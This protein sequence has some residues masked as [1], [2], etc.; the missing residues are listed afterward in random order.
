M[1]YSR[2]AKA[3]FPE[4]QLDNGYAPLTPFCGK[5]APKEA[6]MECRG[7][8]A[9]E[10]GKRVGVYIRVSTEEQ[11]Q[12]ESPE[13]HEKRARMYAEV[14]GWVVVTV[15]NLA[16]FSG[17]TVMGHPECER[18]MADVKEGR[19]DG[20]IFSKLARLAR[21]T[22]ELLD[23][24]DF[25]RE[26][27]ADLISLQESI[28]TST[29]GG[30]FFY[31]I[32]ASLA[33]WEREEIADRVSASVQVRAKLGKSLGGAAPFGYLW[34]DGKLV[35][36]P[37][38]AP[39]RKLMYEL[40]LEERRVK[41][42]A[43]ILNERGYRT[44]RGAKFTGTTV[45]RLLMDPTAKGQHR[46]NYTTSKGTGK[47]WERKAEDEWTY[48]DVEPVVSEEVWNQVNAI[49]DERATKWAKRPAKKPCH[50]FTGLVHCHCGG[51][52]YVPS[53]SPK[54]ICQSCRHKIPV[55]DLERVFAEEL[56]NF[57]FS[58]DEIGAHLARADEEI[59]ES[60]ALLS[61]LE[62][63]RDRVRVEMDKLYRLYQDDGITVEGFR[64]RYRPMEERQAELGDELPRLQARIDFMRIRALSGSEIVGEAQ[65]LSSRWGELPE[66][67]KRGIV[68][69]IVERIEVG[70]GEIAIDLLYLPPPPKAPGGPHS[71]SSPST[72]ADRGRNYRGSSPRAARSGP[73]TRAGRAPAPRRPSP[74]R[75]AGAGPRGRRDETR[76]ARRGTARHCGPGSPRPA[77][78]PN[79]RRADPARWFQ[80][81]GCETAARAPVRRAGARRRASG[82]WSPR[83]PRRG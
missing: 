25:F 45:R 44:R 75:A 64:V 12:G 13:H 22:R 38:E 83:S 18:M 20:L 49:L 29:A 77:A 33:E 76:A 2:V 40:F 71:P 7:A 67:D 58:P 4:K 56:R 21:N 70:L 52:M 24:A 47:A 55:G 14:K 63:E 53:N 32:L 11:A 48:A 35:V 37:A 9:E 60:E 5:I 28:D 23:F 3:E 82:S 61:S 46:R 72:V 31:R 6:T 10:S 74:P 8:R 57:V 27:G 59:A 30:R 80:G 69:T 34:E 26:H 17:K 65:D 50:L 42:V 54:Y 15:Y 73:G 16:G 51:R 79:R 36:D 78:A 19:I 81:A 41:T 68:E 62:R 39:V 66:A 43:R 1:E